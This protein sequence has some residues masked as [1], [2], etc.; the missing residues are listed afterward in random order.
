LGS[1]HVKRECGESLNVREL[2]GEIKV[3]MGENIEPKNCPKLI[4]F[5]EVK[6]TCVDL[7]A[8]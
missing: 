3:I 1:Q 5:L 7:G 2:A 6:Y 8:G 4:D